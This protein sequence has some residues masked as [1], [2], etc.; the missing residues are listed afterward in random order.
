VVKGSLLVIWS[1][2]SRMSLTC[3]FTDGMVTFRIR[4]TLSSC[5]MNINLENVI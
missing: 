4:T 2:S 1:F 5:T 3:Q